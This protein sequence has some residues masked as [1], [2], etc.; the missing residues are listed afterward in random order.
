MKLLIRILLTFL[1]IA[2]IACEA[3]DDGA[4]EEKC[5]SPEQNLDL[6]EFGSDKGCNCETENETKCVNTLPFL[7]KK[8]KWELSPAVSCESVLSCNGTPIPE[9][10][11][12]NKL[13][14]TFKNP[15]VNSIDAEIKLYDYKD[16]QIIVLD[17]CALV[18]CIDSSFEIF[19]CNGERICQRSG[20]IDDESIKC[21]SI[22]KE[23]T[24]PRIIYPKINNSICDKSAI[25]NADLYAKTETK[26]YEI[27]D[28]TWNGKCLSIE[29]KAG[30]CSG[31]TWVT[32][33]ID[34]GVVMESFPIQ[35]NL[36]LSFKNEE[37]CKAFNWRTDFFNVDTLFG[38]YGKITLNIEG[39]EKSITIEKGKANIEIPNDKDDYLKFIKDKRKEIVAMIDAI[40]CE[41]GNDWK[42]IAFGSKPCGGPWEYL[43]YPISLGKTGLLGKIEEYNTTEKE[44]NKLFGVISDCSI[45]KMP[46]AVE[47][48]EGKPNFI[49]N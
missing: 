24:N 20:G 9:L 39:Y 32:E 13:I 19:N 33:L 28:V 21:K 48:K 14:E 23:A 44:G 4:N 40:S 15:R 12:L 1:V 31:E 27:S 29:I 17:Y 7:C 2:N 36:K 10:D 46:D 8:G 18:E 47:C 45:A 35:R 5:F 43:A 16:E 42:V 38:D 11:W 34:A 25:V 3:N 6:A 37:L 41:N 26:G 30:G 22:L 49:Y